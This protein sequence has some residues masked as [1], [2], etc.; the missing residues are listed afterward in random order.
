ME[1]IHEHVGAHLCRLRA[2]APEPEQLLRWGARDTG[3]EMDRK[4]ESKAKGDSLW[5][6]HSAE[7][8]SGFSKHKTSLNTV[9]GHMTPFISHFPALERRMTNVTQQI[10][11]LLAIFMFRKWNWTVFMDPLLSYLPWNTW[12]KQG[13][14][15]HLLTIP[16]LV[17]GSSYIFLYLSQCCY[18]ICVTPWR[19]H[20]FFLI[21]TDVAASITDQCMMIKFAENK[22]RAV[23]TRPQ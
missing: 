14:S 11:F 17:M 2:S 8:R 5:A 7:S 22:A 21:E 20:S 16:T 4:L 13:I 10:C 19:E 1:N 3:T 15:L 9:R 6:R 18:M 23:I 12:S